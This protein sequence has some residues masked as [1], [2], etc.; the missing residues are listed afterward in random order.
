MKLLDYHKLRRGVQVNAH[1]GEPEMLSAVEATLR[2]GLTEAGFTDVEV[3]MTD[4][5]DH[6]VVA[7]C[8][9]PGR[10]DADQAA[11]RLERLWRDRLRH[12]FWE[13][14]A[15]LVTKDQAELL[16]ATRFGPRGGYATVHVVAQKDVA[17]KHVA[18]KDVLI[19]AQRRS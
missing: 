3:E 18:Q 1:P 10:A 8:R 9:F 11:S 16:G 14:H 4:N 12:D 6:L 19:P 5:S 15:T 7:M 2:T 17:Q 13:A